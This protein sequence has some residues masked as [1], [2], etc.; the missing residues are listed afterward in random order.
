MLLLLE[1]T[2]LLLHLHICGI[3]TVA[4]IA[5]LLF[6]L[7]P[8]DLLLLCLG[9]ISIGKLIL[10][11]V[12]FVLLGQHVDLSLA[13]MIFKAV[14]NALL[15]LFTLELLQSGF[16]VRLGNA[17]GESLE[18]CGSQS[19]ASAL[20][21]IPDIRF[22]L[23]KPGVALLIPQQIRIIL[24]SDQPLRVI[25]KLL[26]AHQRR[27]LHLFTFSGIGSCGLRGASNLC[28]DAL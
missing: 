25:A 20:Q 17:I 19:S 26:V 12:D 6:S 8:L 11:V 2:D 22:C 14:P 27:M 13:L 9:S 10:Q 16:G 4:E 28:P 18:S 3:Q 7:Q 21:Y 1:L 5:Q 15:L 24:F 23:S